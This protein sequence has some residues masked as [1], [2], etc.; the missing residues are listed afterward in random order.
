MITDEVKSEMLSTK[1]FGQL[2]ILNQVEGQIQITK[3]PVL[4]IG[5]LDL[6]LI[7]SLV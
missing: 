4:K 6:Y 1:W 5:I 2:T 3:T 7:I